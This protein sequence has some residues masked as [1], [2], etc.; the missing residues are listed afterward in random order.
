MKI[1]AFGSPKSPF[2]S[3]L[4]GL[5]LALSCLPTSVSSQETG[6]IHGRVESSDTHKALAGVRVSVEGGELTAVTGED[7]EFTLSG[8]TSGTIYLTLELLPRFVTSK[9]QVLVRP[10]VTVRA[11]FEMESVAAVLDEI[12]VRGRPEASDALVKVFAPGEAEDM[13]G[14]GTAVDLLAASFSG[15]QVI[16]GSGQA[17][18]GSRLM[19]RGIN[20]LELPGD[21]LVFVDGVRVNNRVA[22]GQ[23]ETTFV[24]GVLDLIPAGAISRIEV[25]KGPSATRFG[26]G[27]SNGVILV[28]TR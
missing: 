14:G 6:T 5:T 12:L 13:I 23:S 16:R 2:L 27:S 19:I 18:A 1:P 9:E 22:S 4:V 28:F 11:L 25:L 26:V 7:G 3:G 10:G 15:I 17:G 20:S 8:V 24:V 21:P